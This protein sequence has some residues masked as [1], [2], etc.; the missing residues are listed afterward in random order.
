MY[1]LKFKKILINKKII[2]KMLADIKSKYLLEMIF[3]FLRKR[4]KLKIVKYNKNL[5]EKLNIVR[6][7]FKQYKLLKETNAKLNLNIED[8]DLTYL[9]LNDKK[10]NEN[11][12]DDLNKIEFIKLKSLIL[13]NNKIK[14]IK[15][16]YKY[17]L[18]ILDLSKNKI[19]EIN[20][21]HN[22]NFTDLKE[23]Y[24]GDNKISSIKLLENAKFKKL[25]ILDLSHNNFSD[26]DD[27]EN[28][29]FEELSYIK[30]IYL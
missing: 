3:D 11:G 25:R 18:E 24:L 15:P 1:K 27:L 17:N 4:I 21:F 20:I 6:E 23:L 2:K 8:T 5:Q 26:F 14:D 29:N 9:D 10:L 19:S 16:L 7:D 12:L 22:N 13:S 30:K 28:L